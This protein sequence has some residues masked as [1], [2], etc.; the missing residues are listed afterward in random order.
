MYHPLPDWKK[1]SKDEMFVF[2]LR[3]TSDDWPSNLSDV[4]RPKC[5]T[6]VPQNDSEQPILPHSQL[7]QSFPIEVAQNDLEQPILHG[8][9]I[10]KKTL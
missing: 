7:F 8:Q 3:S 10:E 6:K 4:S 5:T 9:K 1:S 2:G